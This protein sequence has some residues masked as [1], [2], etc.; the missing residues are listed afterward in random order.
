M[1]QPP[2]SGAP[3][4]PAAPD[5]PEDALKALAERLLAS[6][7]AMAALEADNIRLTQRVAVLESAATGWRTLVDGGGLV[8]FAFDRQGV[9]R[10]LT[11]AAA[12]ILSLPTAAPGQRLAEVT[13]HLDGIDL[14]AEARLALDRGAPVERQ[15]T[16][17]GGA[18]PWLMRLVPHAVPPAAAGEA[19]AAGV[20]ASFVHTGQLARGA[21]RATLAEDVDRRATA[22][23]RAI[24]DA[25]RGPAEPD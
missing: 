5:G 2:G 21:G 17:H 12:A 23:W 8:A 4:E 24:A 25:R 10:W 13:C 20:V 1:P 22:G 16:A 9:I 3:G 19:A 14:E 6:A 15:V 7:W 18:E 11:P